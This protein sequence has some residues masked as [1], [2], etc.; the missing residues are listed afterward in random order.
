M[1]GE[2]DRHEIHQTVLRYCRAVDRLDLAGV[3]AV[4]AEDGVD[5]HTGFSGSAEDF[6]AWLGRMLPHLDGTMH[7]VGNHLSEIDGDQAVAE[8]YGTATHWGTPATEPS[9]NFTSG[10]R[11][12]DHFV[13]TPA[14]WQIRE[15]FAVREWTRDVTGRLS[16]PDGDGPRG[17]RNDQDPLAVLRRRVLG[18]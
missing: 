5:H 1:S 6:V 8:T 4:Y 13:R 12:V 15:R 10:F 14:G 7:L 18:A 11:Y 3:R 2:A 16:P 9:M 17:S